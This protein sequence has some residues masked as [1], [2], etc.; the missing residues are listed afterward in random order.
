MTDP[1]A[2]T[3]RIQ[4]ADGLVGKLPSR[5]VTVGQAYG[6]DDRFVQDPHA[7]VLLQG[8]DQAA[9][10]F[11]GIGLSGLLDLDDLKASRE[12]GVLFEVLLVFGPGRGGDR[13]Q[14]AARQGGFQQIGGITAS[15]LPPGADHGVRLVNE[16][17]HGR[18]RRLDFVDDRLEPVLELALN[19]R[20]GLQ[21][22]QVQRPQG[23]GLQRRGHVA[24]GDSQREAFDHGGLAHPRLAGQD[25][26]VLPAACQDIDDLADFRIAAQ[27]GI[28]VPVAGPGRQI[29]GVLVERRCLRRADR[30][31]RNRGGG[32]RGRCGCLGLARFVR[33][34]HPRGQVSAQGFRR[35][36]LEFAGRLAGHAGQHFVGQERA[37]QM[38]GADLG[39]AVFDRRDHPGFADQIHDLR[40]QRRRAGIAC[41]QAVDGPRHRAD[42]PRRIDLELAQQGRQIGVGDLQQLEQPVLDLDVIVRPRQ[43]QARRALQRAAAGVIQ[44][45]NQ[46]FEID[47]YHG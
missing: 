28:D 42:Q 37:Q 32:A 2:G 35:D 34:R 36:P 23:H 47:G 26:I 1:D 19:P 15:R 5:D 44:F 6:I 40:R 27:D 10:H 13:P 29:D 24:G 11:G 20:P 43:A 31:A 38:P 41:L 22:A 17:D 45:S 12:G 3:G 46:R 4:H 9:E 7:M 18:G 8:A 25:R 21:Q 33:R 16:Q 39:T 30:L 14:L